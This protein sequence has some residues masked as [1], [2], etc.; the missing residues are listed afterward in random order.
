MAASQLTL[1]LRRLRKL[2]AGES[3]A[4]LPDQPLLERFA[5]HGDEAAFEMLL[6]R[7]GPMVLNVCRRVLHNGNAVEDAF[8]ATFL[9]LALK[10]GSIRHS[11]LLANWLYGV[12]YRTAVRARVEAA[13][14]R[15][16]E[17]K[18]PAREATDPLNEMT[19]RELFAVLDE[20]LNRLPSQYRAPLVLCYLENRTRDEAARQVG[21][22]RATVERRLERGRQLLRAR[23]TRRGLTLGLM[24]LPA[25]LFQTRAATGL[26]QALA[27]STL[28]AATTYATGPAAGTAVAP[29]VVALTKGVIRAMFLT[30]L[31]IATAPVLVL[32]MLL[33]GA[34]WLTHHTAASPRA[35]AGTPASAAP[36]VIAGQELPAEV[37]GKAIGAAKV[38]DLTAGKGFHLRPVPRGTQRTVFSPDGTVLALVGAVGCAQVYDPAA[39]TLLALVQGHT[40]PV[41]ALAFSPDGN[42][43]ISGSASRKAKLCQVP[44]TTRAA[45]PDEALP[46]KKLRGAGQEFRTPVHA[47]LPARQKGRT[48]YFTMPQRFPTEAEILRACPDRDKLGKD[49]RVFCELLLYRLDDPRFYPLIGTARLARAHFKCLVQGSLGQ[50]VVYIDRDELVLARPETA[51]R[52]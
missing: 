19:V 28:K 9:V 20:E 40:A 14:R 45:A 46:L 48:T 38:F 16:R 50:A 27:A 7:H 26:A 15:A 47:D 21:C 23:L 12:A 2:S 3:A 34:E 52:R 33:A 22:S 8:Q 29:R 4:A 37:S 35:R 17:E 10:A 43:L 18:T 42:K 1:V 32:G 41:R 25:G 13:K 44:A 5:E 30:K 39:G 51:Q 6:A 36:G 11:E 49:I 31:K 24:L